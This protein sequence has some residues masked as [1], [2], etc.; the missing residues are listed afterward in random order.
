MDHLYALRLSVDAIIERRKVTNDEGVVEI[1]LTEIEKEE[2][3]KLGVTQQ[4][5]G[6]HAI[7]IVEN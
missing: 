7:R 1:Q 2:L 3:D 4:V 5:I 6:E